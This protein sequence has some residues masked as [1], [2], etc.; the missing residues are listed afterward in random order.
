MSREL[1]ISRRSFVKLC[2][3]AAAMVSANPNLLAQTGGLHRYH[4]ARLVDV[5]NRPVTP[6]HLKA[7]ENYLF[8]YPY[9]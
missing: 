5:D 9:L 2:A 1:K 7:G 4:R 6:E 3:S 8:H